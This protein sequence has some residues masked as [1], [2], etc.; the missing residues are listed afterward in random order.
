MRQ[1]TTSNLIREVR[2]LLDE[3]G[4]ESLDDVRDIIPSLNRGLDFACDILSRKYNPP[5][6]TYRF[7]ELQAGTEEFPIPEDVFEEKVTKVEVALDGQFIEVP[8][9]SYRDAAP[10]ETSSSTPY[11]LAH[12]MI[13]RKVRLYPKTTGQYPLRLWYIADPEPLVLEQGTVTHINR[14][15]NYL[16]VGEPG[17]DLAPDIDSL[18]SYVNLV[19][20]QTGILKGTLQIQNISG[21][22]ISFRTTPTRQTVLG[23]EVQG[24]LPAS[25]ELGDFLCSVEGTCI[26]VLKKPVSNYVVQYASSELGSVKFGIESTVQDDI[27]KALETQVERSWAGREHSLRVKMRSP[28][29]GFLRR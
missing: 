29:W 20:G 19:D 6:L 8:R 5:L 16:M 15:A 23:R 18:A 3:E 22:R 21:Q 24:E 4:A 28:T 12:S 2:S 17:K 25:L 1:L 13:G 14:E 7:L 10:L 9:I 11:P 26:C 27:R